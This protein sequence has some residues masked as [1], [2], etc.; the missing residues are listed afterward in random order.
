[1]NSSNYL[2]INEIYA[3]CSIDKD[4]NEGVVGMQIA[5]SWMPF[6]CADVARVDSL[7]PHA[8]KIAKASNMKIRLK[9][10]STVEVVEEF[11]V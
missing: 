6:V 11:E 7:R 10:F 2:R 3:F 5:G 8:V 9:K 4:G 1:M